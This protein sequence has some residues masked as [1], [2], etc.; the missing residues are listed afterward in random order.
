MNVCPI[1]GA[2]APRARPPRSDKP[3]PA[4]RARSPRKEK[5]QQALRSRGDNPELQKEELM[6]GM[7]E[8]RSSLTEDKPR[9]NRN[10]VDDKRK[11]RLGRIELPSNYQNIDEQNYKFLVSEYGTVNKDGFKK[12]PSA[13]REK[14]RPKP[15]PAPVREPPR[16]RTQP[17]PAP[18]RVPKNDYR[19]I[20]DRRNENNRYQTQTQPKPKARP[21]KDAF[22]GNT[23]DIIDNFKYYES[24]NISKK[25][26]ENNKQTKVYH[27]RRGTSED[28]KGH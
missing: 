1:H 25:G 24:V 7:N 8:Y 12:G 16:V 26:M 23:S 6:G 27:R 22:K 9:P 17:K 11:K 28:K 21:G 5:P 18:A 19:R 13:K 20:D 2:Q 3:Q 14:P 10:S 15:Q 4:L